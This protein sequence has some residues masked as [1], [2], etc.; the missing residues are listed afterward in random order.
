MNF[1]NTLAWRENMR[2]D[3]GSF[4]KIEMRSVTLL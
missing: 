3:A 2:V 1:P 4:I